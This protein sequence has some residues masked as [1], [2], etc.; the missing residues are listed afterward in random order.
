ME[1]RV[2]FLDLSEQNEEER[3]ELLA[4]VERVLCHGRFIMGPEVEEFEST[5][6]EYCGRK[7]AVSV[8]SGSDA[9]FLALK[10]LDMGPEDEIITTALSWIATANSIALTGATPVFADIRDDLNID[11]ESVR[12]LITPKTRAILPVHYA[13]KVC[14][15][16]ELFEI[17]KEHNLLMVEDAS[18]AFGAK[19]NG[20]IAGSFGDLACISLNPM[21]LLGACGEA[22]VILTDNS[23]LSKR[24]TALRYNG[25]VD[26]EICFEPGLNARMDT[27][28]AAILL[29]KFNRLNKIIEKR[30]KIAHTY[31]NLLSHVVKTSVESEG[32]HDAY[33]IY[34]ILTDEREKLM[35]HLGAKGIEAKIRDPYLMPEQPAYKDHARGEFPT[36]TSLVKRLMCIPAHEKLTRVETEYVARSVLNFFN[37]A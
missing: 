31:N 14:P 12:R 20:K 19:R 11:P 8:N 36:A 4:A 28:Q 35:D 37:S 9:L 34:P 15:M 25:M 23:N 10:S 26:K 17:A 29:V 5:V 27:M 30:R 22:G 6:A 1:K 32:E 16:D 3:S 21:K 33:Y 7:H 13:G 18:Q 24:L 2:S